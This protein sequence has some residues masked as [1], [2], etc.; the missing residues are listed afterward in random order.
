MSEYE[1]IGVR[2][3][4]CEFVGITDEIVYNCTVMYTLKVYKHVLVR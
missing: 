2:F 3:N 1:R 4:I